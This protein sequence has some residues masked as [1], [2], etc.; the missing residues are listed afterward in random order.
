[1]EDVRRS[2]WQN[3]LVASLGVMLGNDELVSEG[4]QLASQQYAASLQVRHNLDCYRLVIGLGMQ[5][6]ATDV[7]LS[8]SVVVY[9]F[10]L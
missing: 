10:R 5:G 4:L 6:F 9:Y 1:M 8:V 3:S 7:V 2:R